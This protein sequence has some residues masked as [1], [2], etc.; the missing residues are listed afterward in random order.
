MTTLSIL[1]K[2][3]YP[4]QP[5]WRARRQARQMLAAFFVSLMLGAVIIAVMYIQNA[6]L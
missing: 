5:L 6:K 2:V 3:L 1:G 4:Q